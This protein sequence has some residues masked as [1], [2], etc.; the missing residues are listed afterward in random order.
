MMKI[1]TVNGKG[2][3]TP[4]NSKKK[5][6]KHFYYLYQIIHDGALKSNKDILSMAI[7][8]L[9]I[10]GWSVRVTKDEAWRHANM[11]PSADALIWIRWTG[12]NIRKSIKIIR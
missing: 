9:Q 8:T 1:P 12:K 7:S 10:Q 11:P 5:F 3:V 6:G 4:Y 2:W